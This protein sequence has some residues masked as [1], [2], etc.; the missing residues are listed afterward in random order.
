MR[1]RHSRGEAKVVGGGHAVQHDA[2]LV[3]TGD[4]QVSSQG[5][6]FSQNFPS[7]KS[8]WTPASSEGYIPAR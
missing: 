5:W 6:Q 4:R 7:G 3:A 2:G 8:C 1:G